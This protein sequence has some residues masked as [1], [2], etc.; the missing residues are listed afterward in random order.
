MSD[1][2]IE[3][4]RE[5]KISTLPP[6]D[7]DQGARPGEGGELLAE[8][9]AA[10]SEVEGAVGD[11]RRPSANPSAEA[12]AT[13]LVVDGDWL[14]LELF[15]RLLTRRGFNVLTT[16]S[17]QGCFEV[18]G[19]NQIDL[20]LLDTVLSDIDGLEVLTSLRKIFTL[21]DLPVVVVTG[22]DSTDDILKALKLGAN[23]Y[24]IE[25]I[26]FQL[27]VA[28]LETQLSL[29]RANDQVKA[30]N[31][32]LEEAHERVIRL[33]DSTSAALADVAS[34]A[35]SVAEEVAQAVGVGQ[36]GVWAL[37][38][39]RLTMLS[40]EGVAPPGIVD[41]AMILKGAH[42]ERVS[43]TLVPVMGFGSELLGAIVVPGNEGKW[44]PRS[45]G[46]LDA[47]ARQLGGVLELKRA[48]R[49]LKQRKGDSD[50]PI[51]VTAVIAT[52]ERVQVCRL[53]GRCFEPGEAECSK[54]G[55]GA[56]LHSPWPVPYSL[57]DRYQLVRVL[58]KGGMAMVFSALDV[59]LDREVAIKVIN[60]E[61]VGNR[62]MRARFKQEA[63]A[64]ASIHD[65]GVVAIYDFGELDTGAFYIVMER[66]RGLDLEHLVRRRGAGTPREV[67]AFLRQG[68]AALDAAHRAKVIHRDLKPGNFF[69]VP[70]ADDFIVKVLDFGLA[71][72]LS[73]KAD[74]TRV[75]TIVGT[76]MYMSPEQAMG[77]RLDQ[78]SDI[79]SFATV[80]FRA[81]VGA[82]YSEQKSYARIL[83]DV[84]QT[85]PPALSTYLPKIPRKVD[86]SF[87]W[88]LAKR[89]EERP[90]SAGE[91]VASFA[92]ALETS[93]S[94]A[95]GWITADGLLAGVDW[96]HERDGGEGGAQ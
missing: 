91:W 16:T 42:H 34:W 17:G 48:R 73:V 64:V 63:Q 8:Q 40:A 11:P 37:E 67:A 12:G 84:V 22:R 4:P 54:C 55:P 82:H 56:I 38:K 35:S 80:A 75:G 1:D 70:K 89:P 52:R 87:A 3:E 68:A 66:L 7:D 44:A 13:I 43:D 74:L 33:V 45:R 76:P 25:P 24:I 15:E 47:F 51:K 95:Q 69:L 78:R 27:I 46:L 96:T 88:A 53:C 86:K 31:R 81:L 23:D 29:K 28:R 6:L 79:Y 49:E 30:L 21:A 83:V 85:P 58:G 59:R 92:D 19:S 32:Q 77:R 65:T 61:Y 14:K 62:T 2:E 10:E 9:A 50:D 94:K 93:S 26:D 57:A 18:F 72:R 36:V 5:R 71:R 39:D 60:P 41:L 20:V 90:R